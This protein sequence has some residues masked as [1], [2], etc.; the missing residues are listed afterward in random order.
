MEARGRRVWTLHTGA[1]GESAIVALE[2][3]GFRD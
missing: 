3:D 1:L 2:I